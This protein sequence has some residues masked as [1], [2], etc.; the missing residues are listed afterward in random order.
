M[1]HSGTIGYGNYGGLSCVFAFFIF[2]VLRRRLLSWCISRIN[3]EKALP[4]EFIKFE[5]KDNQ[6]NKTRE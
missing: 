6:M 1:L 4:E 3:F 2:Y 5:I